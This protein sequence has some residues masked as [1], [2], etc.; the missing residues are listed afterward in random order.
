MRRDNMYI[1]GHEGYVNVQL[2]FVTMSVCVQMK[3]ALRKCCRAKFAVSTV[4]A[5]V[6]S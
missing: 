2:I 6:P 5:A 4:A 1:R 3:E